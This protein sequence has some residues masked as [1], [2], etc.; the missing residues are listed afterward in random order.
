MPNYGSYVVLWVKTSLDTSMKQTIIRQ[1]VALPRKGV[2]GLVEKLLLSVIQCYHLWMAQV[3]AYNHGTTDKASM[4]EKG[5]W[6]FPCGS[7]G[8]EETLI[9][10]RAGIILCRWTTI[11]TCKQDL[12]EKEGRMDCS[13]TEILTSPRCTKD[14]RSD[15]KRVCARTSGSPPWKKNLWLFS[16][17]WV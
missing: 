14:L 5:G 6:N 4:M 16:T 12:Q 8:T 9:Y 17:L 11:S 1:I 15:M 3:F 7:N 2:W 10:L 13:Q